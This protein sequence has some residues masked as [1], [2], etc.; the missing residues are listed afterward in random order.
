MFKGK[1]NNKAP[2]TSLAAKNDSHVCY[3]GRVNNYEIVF[4]YFVIK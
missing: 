2:L 1:H 4:K 3:D